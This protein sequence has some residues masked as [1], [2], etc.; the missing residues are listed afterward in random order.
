MTSLTDIQI[1]QTQNTDLLVERLA[2]WERDNEI[3]RNLYDTTWRGHPITR[4]NYFDW[5]FLQKP[6]GM[7]IGYC[8]TPSDNPGL[9][10]GVYAVI[11]SKILVSGMKLEFGTSLYT[12]THPRYYRRGIFGRL[13]NLTYEE[14]GRRGIHGT[15]GVPNNR[16]LPGFAKGLDFKVIGQFRVLGR[17]ARLPRVREQVFIRRGVSEEDLK[18]LK[19]NLDLIKANTGA[20]LAERSYD[21]LL[22]RF[23]RCPGVNYHISC[24]VDNSN[25][26]QGLAVLRLAKKRKLRITVLV[27]FLVNMD[28]LEANSIARELL[29]QADRFAW[30]NFAPVIITLT[31]AY[32]AEAKLL[33]HDKFR[34]LPKAI[35]PHDSNFILKLHR[36]LPGGTKRLLYDFNRWCF[37]FADYDIF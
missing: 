24:A 12:M 19:L 20:V 4:K 32:S 10:A 30:R 26:V 21:F 6:S 3:I 14:C 9:C 1:H 5:Q 17:L 37:S 33:F 27:D 13:A 8:A 35:L 16:S 31:N 15:I 34:Y 11:P 18:L 7:G 36:N 28:S 22:W 29:S 2:D 25:A 23:F